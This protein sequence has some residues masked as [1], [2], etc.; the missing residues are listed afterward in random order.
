LVFIFVLLI[1]FVL[2]FYTFTLLKYLLLNIIVVF[3]FALLQCLPFVLLETHF[4]FFTFCRVGD[5][6]GDN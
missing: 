3:P 1:H 2:L 5:F 4:S 6:L